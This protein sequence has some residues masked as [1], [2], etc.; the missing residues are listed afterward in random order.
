TPP[1]WAG[2]G[3]LRPPIPPTCLDVVSRRSRAPARS[4]KTPHAH[5]RF[6]DSSLLRRKAAARAAAPGDLRP[7]PLMQV[8]DERPADNVGQRERAGDT[9]IAGHHI[10]NCE[11]RGAG[12]GPPG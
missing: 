5:R 8:I 4:M 12:H 6:N 7:Q 3:A 10:S 2:S 9:E 1:T 11:C